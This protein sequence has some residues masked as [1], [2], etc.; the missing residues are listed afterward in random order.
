MTN[1]RDVVV[2]LEAE[3]VYLS[4]AAIRIRVG[5]TLPPD[6]Y[7]I[8]LSQVYKASRDKV[9]TVEIVDLDK[10]CDYFFDISGWIALKLF[11][12]DD[13]AELEEMNLDFIEVRGT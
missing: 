5:E 10:E 1:I 2:T 4:K 11:D 7:W 12:V 8:P 3:F 9:D 6:F 13:I